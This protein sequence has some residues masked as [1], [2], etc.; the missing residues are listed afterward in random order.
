MSGL[1]FVILSWDVTDTSQTNEQPWE[2]S[3]TQL[4]SS[5]YWAESR[6]IFAMQ[7]NMNIFYIIPREKV[8]FCSISESLWNWESVQPAVD[9]RLSTGRVETLQNKQCGRTVGQNPIPALV[10]VCFTN[11]LPRSHH[12]R[13]LGSSANKRRHHLPVLWQ[14]LEIVAGIQ[15]LLENRLSG[16][17][18][19]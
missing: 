11:L 18:K 9:A 1:F 3:A 10:A 7:V 19:Q 2:D 14:K 4:L 15:I 12:H 13:L 5:M 6:N 8:W 16:K 17:P